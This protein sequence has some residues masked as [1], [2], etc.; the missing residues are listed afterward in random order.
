MQVKKK[1][2]YRLKSHHAA[3]C[4]AKA[5][6]RLGINSDRLPNGIGED[7]EKSNQQKNKQNC[8]HVRQAI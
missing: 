7:V 5:S 6:L 8:P 3:C 2:V 4:F 1:I